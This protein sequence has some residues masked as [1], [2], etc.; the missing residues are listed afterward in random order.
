ATA[1]E[2]DLTPYLSPGEH[3]ITIRVDNRM[4]VD[5]GENA[6]SVSDHTQTNWNGIIGTLALQA[7]D[8]VW[9]ADVQIF[10]NVAERSARVVIQLANETGEAVEGELNLAARSYNAP[11]SHTPAPKSVPFTLEGKRAEYEVVYELGSDAQLWDEF[12]PALYRLTVTVAAQARAVASQGKAHGLR[13]PHHAQ[14]LQASQALHAS[15][16]LHAS[17][18]PQP[19]G[20]RASHDA[21]A[22][23]DPQAS[24][25]LQEPQDPQDS[26]EPQDPQETSDRQAP[27]APH[28]AHA[29]QAGQ[30]PRASQAPHGP[31][32]QHAP[33]DPHAP[34]HPHAPYDP[35]HQHDP[36]HPQG[37]ASPQFTDTREVTFGLREFTTQGTQFVINGRKTFLR[38]TLECAIFPLTGYPATD[39]ASWRRIM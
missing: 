29:L 9:I 31:R 24:R 17:Q 4:V 27:H 10:P 5:V 36:R 21:L 35:C 7:F 39:V 33:H 28:M 11:S 12:H 34:H 26:Q 25:A 30:D 2:Y 3:T 6:H 23:Q 18:T 14:V 38:G 13:A 8:P 1:H 37:S 16:G 15:Q 20:L 32:R 22:R 19:R